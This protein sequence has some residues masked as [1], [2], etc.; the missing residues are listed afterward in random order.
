[1]GPHQSEIPSL[2]LPFALIDG[3]STRHIWV[4][5]ARY[6]KTAGH[7]CFALLTMFKRLNGMALHPRPVTVVWL[8]AY[9]EAEEDKS[10][11][12]Q[13]LEAAMSV[14]GVKFIHAIFSDSLTR[15]RIAWARGESVSDAQHGNFWDI[16]NMSLNALKCLWHH[17]LNNSSIVLHG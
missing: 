7:C 17:V 2:L 13:Q 3:V 6:L 14:A 10:S 16:S 1:M 15:A 9:V 5:L 4:S 11:S 12:Q 8:Q